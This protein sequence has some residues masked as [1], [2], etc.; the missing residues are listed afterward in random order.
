MAKLTGSHLIARSLRAEG[1][2]TLFG[3][4]GD[5]ILHL[6]DI[7]V[8]EPFRM[9]D[10]RHE[11]ASVHMANAY[12]RLLR[13]PG[14]V[15]STTPGHANAVAGLANATHAEAPVINIVG[16]ANSANLGRGAMQEFDQVGL[17]APV[18]KGAWQIPSAERIP[19]FLALAVRVAMDGRRGPVHLTI[20]EDVQMAE[21]DEAAAGR[22]RPMEYGAPREQL[23]D[24]RQ[25]EQAVELLHAAE[26]PV[27]LAGA[28]AGATADPLELQ[29]LVEITRI[30]LFTEDHARSLIPDSHPYAMGLGYMPLNKALQHVRD[31]DVVL[32]LGQRLDYMFGYG[33]SP[34]FAPD[35]KHVMVEPSAAEIGRARTVAIGI[36]ADVGPAITQLADQAERRT[37]NE[38]P[39]VQTLRDADAAYQEELAEL[40]VERDPMHPM[41]VSQ[42]LR[43]L[44]DDDTCLVVDGG[45]YCHFFRASFKAENPFRWLYVSSFGMI[46][47]GLPYA[48]GAQAA[49]PDKRV[50]LVV[51][52]GSFGF[53]AL[54]LDTAVRHN[55]NVVAVLGNNS[56]WGIDWQI[57]KGLYGRPVW[58]DLLPT[59]YDQVAAGLGAHA[60]HVTRAAELAPALGRALAAGK[61]ALVNVAVGKIISPVAE[62]AVNRKLGS[63]G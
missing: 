17:A 51:G 63:H 61:P 11:A 18:T 13:R 58:T 31:A 54:E 55:L 16:S 20:P 40:A 56:I 46:G 45:D 32:L 23:G 27:I 21:V 30:P 5:H 62:A 37:W 14:V 44:V 22:Y 43:K 15:L 36:Q 38:L 7:L 50:V 49:L 29:R 28:G 34:P 41:F 39:W 8:D 53:H 25:V 60:E 33:G 59:R 35:V 48:L 57:Q 4:A 19:E 47:V 26:R 24:P 10:G 3:I 6:L 12:A 52:D 9:I 1:V 42:E 2:D